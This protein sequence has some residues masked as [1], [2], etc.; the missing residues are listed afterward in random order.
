MI[1]SQ[2]FLVF[3]N[4]DILRSTGQVFYRIS[5]DWNLS[6]VFFMIRCGVIDLGKEITQIKCHSHHII[7]R[8]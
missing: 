1:V 5:L 8:V 2:I 4:L 7:P 6:D 3:D